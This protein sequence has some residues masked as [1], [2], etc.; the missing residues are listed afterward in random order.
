MP[1]AQ[2]AMSL[3]MKAQVVHGDRLRALP[4]VQFGQREKV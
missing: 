4:K 1:T 3:R 2:Q